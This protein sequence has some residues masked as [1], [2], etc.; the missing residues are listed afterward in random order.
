MEKVAEF[1]NY[2]NILNSLSSE[3][4]KVAEKAQKTRAGIAS[5]ILVL[6]SNL[7][8]GL[9]QFTVDTLVEEGATFLLLHLRHSTGS[10]DICDA[11][12]ETIQIVK[13]DGTLEA[14]NTS[15]GT[16]YCIFR[17]RP[18]NGQSWNDSTRAMNE[19]ESFADFV[20]YYGG[21]SGNSMLLPL[22]PS[23]TASRHPALIKL[24]EFAV[25][26]DNDANEDMATLI[27]HYDEHRSLMEAWS[28]AFDDMVSTA[29]S[30]EMPLEINPDLVQ[31]IATMD[32]TYDYADRPSS[33][34]GD[35]DSRIIRGLKSLPIA[36]AIRL[37]GEHAHH[38]LGYAMY[39]LVFHPQ[40][41][42]DSLA[43]VA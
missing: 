17:T 13:L 36:N 39:R 3:A 32:W 2:K 4:Y 16:T 29:R 40:Y 25:E 24:A 7:P 30:F 43:K 6:K 14:V 19:P 35:Q 42:K 18:A 31:D 27:D 26:L 15:T 28:V 22:R 8:F 37:L 21:N 12:M 20:T 33:K 23:Q 10:Y 5:K 11:R 38:S 9:R 34:S 1:F 41:P